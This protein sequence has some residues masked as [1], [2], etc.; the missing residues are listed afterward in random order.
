MVAIIIPNLLESRQSY[1]VALLGL[2][3][4]AC[5][6]FLLLVLF[7]SNSLDFFLADLGLVVAYNIH[8][9]YFE[10]NFVVCQFCSASIFFLICDAY[11]QR[12]RL[13]CTTM[14]FGEVSFGWVSRTVRSLSPC[15]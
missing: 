8:N 7:K 10:G 12:N 6:F 14:H 5:L 4:T 3:I 15:D 9:I 13:Q 11:R 1:V 2:S